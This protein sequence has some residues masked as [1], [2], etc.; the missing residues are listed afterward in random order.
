MSIA[1]YAIIAV[2]AAAS[3]AVLAAAGSRQPEDTAGWHRLRPGPMHWVGLGLSAALTGL[4][5]WI[6]LF[7][8]SSRAD[9]EQQMAI[10]FWLAIAFGLGTVAIGH[11]V[12]GIRR[13]AVRWR[14]NEI[15]H[16]FGGGENT[17]PFAAITSMR[18][19]LTGVVLTFLDGTNLTVDPNAVSAAELIEAV[20]RHLERS[21]ES[22]G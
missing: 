1:Y 12:L 14:R 8:G 6:W 19:G 16:A 10:L 4:L 2:A 20:G 22:D 9:A 18:P 5:A 11:S 17:R 3:V 13:A 15:S 21:A 7:V